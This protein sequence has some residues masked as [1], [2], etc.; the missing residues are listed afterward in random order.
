MFVAVVPPEAVLEEL[1]EFAEPRQDRADPL[2]WSDPARWHLTLAFMAAVPE[3]RYETFAERVQQAVERRPPLELA[4]SGAG[5]FPDPAQAK[6]L[7]AGVSGDTDALA[8][9]S[10]GVR[11]AASTSGIAVDGGTFHPHLTLARVSPPIDL[12]RWLR[13]FDLYAGQS[14]RV[15]QIEV[16]ESQLG[17]RRKGKS[18]HAE[19][20]VR[21]VFTLGPPAEP[22]WR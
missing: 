11:T 6:V 22:G 2:R 4:I 1:Q 13:V 18:G 3:D 17:N 19:H 10:S 9:L 16:I 15:E 8:R 20:V 21:D 14:W 12:T 5:A 7:W